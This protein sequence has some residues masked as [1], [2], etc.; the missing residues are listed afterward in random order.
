MAVTSKIKSAYD[1]KAALIDVS[2][3]EWRIS[4]GSL[5]EADG[6]QHSLMS[7]ILNGGLRANRS[8]APVTAALIDVSDTEWRFS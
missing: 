1:S 3:T 5:H 4:A 8:L 2:D 6:K 7:A